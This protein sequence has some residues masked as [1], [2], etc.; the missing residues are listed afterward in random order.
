[1]VEDFL[2]DW[3]STPSQ[4]KAL[5]KMVRQT[6]KTQAPSKEEWEQMKADAPDDM[7]RSWFQ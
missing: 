3:K 4:K 2:P 7:P 1:M 5:E 6:K